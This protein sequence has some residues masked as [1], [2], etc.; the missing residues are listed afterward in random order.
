LRDSFVKVFD[1][2]V[3]KVLAFCDS[4]H[5]VDA[6]MVTLHE[7][8]IVV[9]ILEEI[10][11][12]LTGNALFRKSSAFICPDLRLYLGQKIFNIW[13]SFSVISLDKCGSL[14]AFLVLNIKVEETV[15]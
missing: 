2:G 12:E 11:F 6:L 13:P 8:N 14:A 9:F 1:F 15:F 5:S 7:F 3:N 4:H 10:G